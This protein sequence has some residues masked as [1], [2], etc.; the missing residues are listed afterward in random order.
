LSDAEKKA[1]NPGASLPVGQVP[2]QSDAAAT[3]SR[4]RSQALRAAARAAV[5]PIAAAIWAA[6]GTFWSIF[7]WYHQE[8]VVPA[9]A[10]VNLTTDVTVQEAGTGHTRTD[11]GN[12]NLDAIQVAVTAN[13]VS[14][15]PIH[16]L[17]NYWDA[18]GGAVESR[19]D[20]ADSAA[21][22]SGINAAQADQDKKGQLHYG[23]S[24][25][26][27]NINKFERVAWG[28]L[29]PTTYVLQPKETISASALFYVPKGMYDMVHV[30]IHIPTT[31][32]PNVDVMFTVDAKGVQPKIYRIGKDGARQLVAS[33]SDLAQLK[34]QETQ[35]FREVSLRNGAEAASEGGDAS[36]L[37][38]VTRP[39]E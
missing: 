14:T 39:S 11:S 37:G 28:N 29:F 6:L 30:E 8:V 23:L 3:P 5:V 17:A 15:K 20:D 7:A 32:R 4:T 26:F 24:G 27:Y 36:A 1:P 9:A 33:A 22:I 13:N 21:W 35:A 18:W 2:P 25:R 16:M 12:A 19:G 38:P 34:I 10:P 31:E